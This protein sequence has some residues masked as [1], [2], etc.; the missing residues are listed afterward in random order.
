[1]DLFYSARLSPFVAVPICMGEDWYWNGPRTKIVW[2]LC[3]REPLNTFMA[4]SFVN[5]VGILQSLFF[6]FQ[7]IWICRA[8]HSSETVISNSIKR[9]AFV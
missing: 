4:V 9:N 7:L 8:I 1:M 5:K 3:E 2:M 6:F